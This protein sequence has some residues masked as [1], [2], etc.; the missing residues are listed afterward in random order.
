MLNILAGN[1][2]SGEGRI[3]SAMEINLKSLTIVGIYF[4]IATLWILLSDDLLIALFRQPSAIAL[5]SKIKGVAFIA[6]TGGLA[7]CLL[8]RGERQHR[9]VTDSLRETKHAWDQ[10]LDAFPMTVLT[11]DPAGEIRTMN[12]FGLV[13]SGFRS[14]DIF[15]KSILDLADPLDRGSLQ[16]AIERARGGEVVQ[17]EARFRRADGSVIPY[18]FQASAITDAAGR[19]VGLVGAA[20]DIS[21]RLRDARRLSQSFDGLHDLLEQTI[22]A[23]SKLIEKRDPYTAGHQERVTRLAL[24]IAE[25]LDLDAEMM[26]GLRF[27]SLCHDIGKI[28]VPAE[29]LSKPVRLSPEEFAIIRLH[30][31]SGCDILREIEFP[32]PVAEIVLQHHERLDGSGYPRGLK[33]DQI[34]REARILA[35]ADVVESMLHY[36]PYRAPLGLDAAL[37]EIERGRGRLYDPAAVDSCISAFRKDGF[38]LEPP[39]LE[40]PE[41]EAF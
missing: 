28:N 23:V 31:R 29:I 37:A 5:A 26:K 1:M 32:W 14:Q 15:G 33:G 3:R 13:D 38:A 12:R 27:A 9:K 25:R 19:T 34:M 39:P 22:A 20:V 11:T 21:E 6:V 41:P 7:Y 18:K 30:P 36:R 24:A 17:A 10:S 35:V 40:Q 8:S 4:I 16:G 2:R